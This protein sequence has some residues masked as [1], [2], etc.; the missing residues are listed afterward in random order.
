MNIWDDGKMPYYD[1]TNEF[2][3][4]LTPYTIDGAKGA[5]LVCP[6]GGYAMRAEHE[7]NVIAEWLNSIGVSAFVLEYRVA[8]YAAPAE[9]SDVQR[10]M[11]I[12]R[13]MAKK[14]GYEKI[15]VMGF[16]AGAH[17]AATVSVHYDVDFYEPIDEIDEISA[18]PDAS[19]LCY[20]V[21][22]M[23]EYRHDGSRCNLIG[24]NPRPDMKEFYSLHLN[25][26][27]DTPPAFLWHTAE[28]ATVPAENSMLYASALSA[29]K[30]PYELH[31]YPFGHHGLGLA[32]EVPH[33]HQWAAALDNWLTLM[34]WK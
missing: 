6:G 34:G 1:E 16:S 25:V 2:I 21:I 28:D 17:L 20:P 29:H 12:V 33:T 31:I 5:V 11:R 27:D 4:Y 3:P 23:Y 19:I 32:D 13:S 14:Y 9:G 24:T 18:R 10:A 8:P 7:G 22:D 30:I 15:A 26:T